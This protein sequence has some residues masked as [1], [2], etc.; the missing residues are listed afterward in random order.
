MNYKDEVWHFKRTNC[1]RQIV[2]F[3][4]CLKL[5]LLNAVFEAELNNYPI[6]DLFVNTRSINHM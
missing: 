5:M 3:T 4:I 1:Y 2:R 6:S